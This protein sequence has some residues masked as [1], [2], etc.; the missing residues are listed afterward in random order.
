MIGGGAFGSE[1]SD[2]NGSPVTG[3]F[4]WLPAG[5][6]FFDL[7]GSISPGGC[8]GGAFSI[9]G[10]AT[11]S[12]LRLGCVFGGGG[13]GIRAASAAAC[14]AFAS[15]MLRAAM[16]WFTVFAILVSLGGSAGKPGRRT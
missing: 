14:F 8:C 12:A 2:M 4:G 1:E 7:L 5:C 15:A 9:V 13:G 11:G 6:Q 10:D 3:A 16:L